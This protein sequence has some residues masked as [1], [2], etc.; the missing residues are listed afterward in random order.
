MNLRFA[1]C[2][3][4]SQIGA[5]AWNTLAE[6]AGPFLRYEFLS[7]LE[8][9]ACVSADTGW[10][11]YH[12]AVWQDDGEGQE[13]IAALMPLYKKHHSYGEYV[14]DWSWADAYHQSGLRYYPKLLTSIPF[15]PS[16]GTRVLVR[17]SSQEQALLKAILIEVA[18]EAKRQG[19]SSWHILFPEKRVSD[20][21]AREGAHQ[22]QGT[23]FH[24]Y[25]NS[26]ESF[27]NFLESFTSRKRKNIKKERKSVSLSGI[28]FDRLE[29]ADITAED[30]ARFYHFYQRTYQVRGQQGYLNEAFFT[31]I[32]ETMADSI[33]LVVAKKDGQSIA[34]ALSFKDDTRLYGRYWGCLEEYQFLHFE[35][36]YYQG[37]EYAID[38]GLASFDSG[39]QGEHKIQRGFKPIITYS[40]HWIADPRFDAAIADYLLQERKHSGMYRESAEQLL[41]FKVKN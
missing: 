22:R 35:T 19:N 37:I 9:S 5:E 33:L 41:P 7:A 12:L 6:G 15:T 30:W 26:Y 23:Q 17:E 1:Y 25:N 14:F 29:G 4:V 31:R 18:A 11:P 3:S 39:A 8:E 27:D 40:N 24:W 13:R 2:T 10:E 20:L 16:Y 34:A 32:G 36:C 38:K 21:L 28:S